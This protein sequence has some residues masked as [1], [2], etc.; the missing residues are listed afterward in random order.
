MPDIRVSTVKFNY[1]QQ[2]IKVTI[3]SSVPC[4]SDWTTNLGLY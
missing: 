3:N 1:N 4:D 2:L